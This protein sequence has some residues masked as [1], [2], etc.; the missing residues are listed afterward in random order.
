MRVRVKVEAYQKDLDY[1]ER[2]KLMWSPVYE[3]IV[4]VAE[5]RNELTT[6]VKAIAETV[7]Q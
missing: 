3:Q 5:D 6:L 1:N 4:E 7:N 2:E